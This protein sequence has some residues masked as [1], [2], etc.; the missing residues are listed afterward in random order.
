MVN[1]AA[2][3]KVQYLVEIKEHVNLFIVNN[4]NVNHGSCSHFSH[5][6][7]HSDYKYKS[8][9]ADS[10]LAGSYKFQVSEIEVYAKKLNTVNLF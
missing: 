6:Y 4:P 1:V 3:Q 10:L 8:N 5:Y 7:K 9:R 2:I